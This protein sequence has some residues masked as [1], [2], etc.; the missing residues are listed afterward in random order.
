MHYKRIS[1]INYFTD[2]LPYVGK[3]DNAN[4]GDNQNVYMET[5]KIFSNENLDSSEIFI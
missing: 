4:I 5:S 1:I 3:I 2:G